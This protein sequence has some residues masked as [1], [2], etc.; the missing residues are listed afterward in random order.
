[1]P[2][3]KKGNNECLL[4]LEECV[5]YCGVVCLERVIMDIRH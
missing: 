4:L 1:M 3:K 5:A 2:A